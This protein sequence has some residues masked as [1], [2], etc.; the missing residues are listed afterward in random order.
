MQ[1]PVTDNFIISI[2]FGSTYFLFSVTIFPNRVYNM[3]GNPS[4]SSSNVMR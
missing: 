4:T 2:G 1:L 3:G